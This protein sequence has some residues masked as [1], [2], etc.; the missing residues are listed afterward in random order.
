[1][2]LVI[3]VINLFFINVTERSE[4]PVKKKTRRDRPR[5]STSGVSRSRGRPCKLSTLD[6]FRTERFV[7]Y[8]LLPFVSKQIDRH[9]IF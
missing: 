7:F 5:E 3:S 4:R 6:Q 2:W 9:P 8:S 1:M